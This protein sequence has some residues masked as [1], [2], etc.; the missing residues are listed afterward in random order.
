MKNN[1]HGRAGIIIIVIFEL[2]SASIAVRAQVYRRVAPQKPPLPGPAKVTLPAESRIPNKASKRVL[3]K[4]LKGLVFISSPSALI[5]T[6]F[7][8]TMPRDGVVIHSLPFLNRPAFLHQMSEFVGQP[9]TMADIQK[10][11]QKVVAWYASQGHSL[12]SVTVPPQD[13]SS[14]VVQII[15]TEYRVGKVSVAGNQWFSSNLIRDESGIQTGKPITLPQLR[16]DLNWLNS[17]PFR[18]VNAVFTPGSQAGQTDVLLQTKDQLPVRVYA[19]YDNEGVPSLGRS[20]YNVGV[21][22]GNAFGLDQ[23]LSY[24][25]TRSLSGQYSA[26]SLDWMIPLPWR[27]RLIIFGSYEEEKPELGSG[28]ASIGQS[29]QASLR[30]M[31]ELPALKWLKQD[32]GF[33][34]DFKTTNNNLEFGGTQVGTSQNSLN[35]LLLVYHATET[36]PFGNTAVKNQFVASIGA[37]RGQTNE[38]DQTY[39]SSYVY[40]Q[41]ELNRITFLPW[42]FSS[43][44]RFLGQ[45]AD[46]NLPDSETL[47]AGGEGSVRGYNPETDLGSE[48]ELI[49]EEIR[50]PAFDPA[51]FMNLPA[52]LHSSAQF[53]VF[54]DYA[55][56]YQVQA[57]TNAPDRADLASMGVDLHY[58]VGTNLSMEMDYGQQLRRAPGYTSRGGEFDISVIVSF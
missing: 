18:Q 50:A 25:Y 49:S 52:P 12:M 31:H 15:V 36:D 9:F 27:D 39:P 22:W 46:H 41:F 14:G 8:G 5:K 29:G 55:D 32:I 33:G 3:L 51:G 40:D 37:I 21:N 13:I 17:N 20:E 58:V 57:V 11:S 19:G 26:H 38:P 56:V 23:Q 6:G 10:I 53:G 45:V 28:F 47:D 16:D 4:S 7:H 35:Q 48:G 43:A 2:C 24:Q 34:Y 54:I 1:V 42:G 44:T 30:Y